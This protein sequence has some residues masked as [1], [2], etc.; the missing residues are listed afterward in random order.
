[1][2]QVESATPIFLHVLLMIRSKNIQRVLKF[3]FLRER[4]RGGG[5]R[6]NT[7]SLV[8][9]NKQFSL[10]VGQGKAFIIALYVGTEKVLWPFAPFSQLQQSCVEKVKMY[11]SI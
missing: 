2:T 6:Y 5:G 10:V 11:Q 7:G 8:T 9:C 4:G 3:T 1:M